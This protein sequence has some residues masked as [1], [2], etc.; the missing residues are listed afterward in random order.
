MTAQE[1]L[2]R[3]LKR[4]AQEGRKPALIGTLGD[5]VLAAL[6]R[7]FGKETVAAWR[8]EG[9]QRWQEHLRLLERPAHG[10]RD[11]DAFPGLGIRLR[12]H[13]IAAAPQPRLAGPDEPAPRR[14]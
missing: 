5:A 3:R 9:R 11:E 8:R 6:E 12:R 14:P 10:V 2:H 4:L 7:R 1:R 13:E